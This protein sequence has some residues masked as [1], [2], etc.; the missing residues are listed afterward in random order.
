MDRDAVMR[1]V[2]DIRTMVSMANIRNCTIDTGAAADWLRR[3][4]TAADDGGRGGVVE[5]PE[6]GSLKENVESLLSRSP[7]T[8]RARPGGGPEDLALSLVLTFTGMEQ[9]ITRPAP[10][11][12]EGWKLVPE[13][14]H[15]D[16]D[17]LVALSTI[18]GNG[19]N[20]AQS[21]EDWNF[22]TLWIGDCVDDDGNAV[23]GLHASCDECPEEGCVTL[24]EFPAFP[25]A[26]SPKG[27]V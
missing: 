10:A 19:D 16:P 11:V 5:S 20:A 8:V 22:T 2:S 17:S 7:H 25:A 9:K 24:A 18:S 12:P 14:I 15:L 21:V 4:E 3:L 23:H 1:V 27:D 26:P 6:G 13:K